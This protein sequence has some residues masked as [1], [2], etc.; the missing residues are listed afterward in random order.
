M[1]SETMVSFV[2]YAVKS[3]IRKSSPDIFDETNWMNEPKTSKAEHFISVTK[4]SI[5][6]IIIN[7]TFKLFIN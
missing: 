1:P 3:R 4:K 2:H 6:V 5:F 7:I